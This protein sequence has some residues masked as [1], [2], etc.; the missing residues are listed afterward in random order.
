MET[1]RSKQTADVCVSLTGNLCYRPNACNRIER[2]KKLS[3]FPAH[4][5]LNPLPLG[6]NQD[7]F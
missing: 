6:E 2:F 3:G 4:P 5:K 1:D 7:K